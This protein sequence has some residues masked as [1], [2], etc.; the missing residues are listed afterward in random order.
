MSE[1]IIYNTEQIKKILPH[2]HP[3]LLVENVHE[4]EKSNFI[5]ASRNLTLDEQ[6]FQGHFPGNPIYPGVYTIEGMAQCGAILMYLTFYSNE[7]KPP[8][9]YFS[10]IENVRFKKSATVGDKIYYDV[11]LVKHKS[12]FYWF[13]G[14]VFKGEKELIASAEFSLAVV[15]KK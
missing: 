6:V 3:F 15:S 10:S 11:K 2:R 8:L 14:N 4:L 7:E 9:G 1:K 12:S 5:L 13:E